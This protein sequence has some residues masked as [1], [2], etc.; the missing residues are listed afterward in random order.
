MKV[1]GQTL[2]R[3]VV[4]VGGKVLEFQFR[5]VV[6]AESWDPIE[7][8]LGLHLPHSYEKVKGHNPKH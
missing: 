3:R 4:K 5:H 7:V 6:G 2:P 1:A 8:V